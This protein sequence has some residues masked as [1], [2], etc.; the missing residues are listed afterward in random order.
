MSSVFIR[1]GQGGSVSFKDGVATVGDLPIIGNS[2]G[3]VRSALDTKLLYIWDGT[4][5]SSTGG[6]GGGGTPGSPSGSIQFNTGGVFTGNAA[7]TWD[8][9]GKVL[10]LNGLAIRALSSSI[11]LI[12]NQVAPLTALSFPVA[13]FNFS[14]IEYSLT[15]STSKQVGMLFIA[16]DGTSATLAGPFADLNSDTGIVFSALVT[17]GNVEL[18]YTSSSTGF[19]AAFRYSIRQWI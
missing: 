14:I 8:N 18:Q 16:N 12:D 11:S 17:G 5:W 15:R 1:L 9:S 13:T 3:D 2:P 10:N 19:N 7:L 6:G 4:A